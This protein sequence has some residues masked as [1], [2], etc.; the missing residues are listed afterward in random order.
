MYFHKR[1][2]PLSSGFDVFYRSFVPLS[3]GFGC[4]FIRV[5]SSCLVVMDIFS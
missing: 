3:S 5:V 2:V 4:M 1:C